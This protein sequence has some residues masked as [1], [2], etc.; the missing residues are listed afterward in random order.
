[1]CTN[2]G[3]CGRQKTKK[4][5]RTMKSRVFACITVMTLFVALAMPARLAGQV[6][7]T[8]TAHRIPMW[9]SNTTLGDS[10]I[11]QTGVGSVGT[12]LQVT[13]GAGLTGRFGHNGWPGGSINLTGGHGGGAGTSVSGGSG[14]SVQITGGTGGSGTTCC[15]QNGNGNGGSITLQPGA[16]GTFVLTHGRSGNV[17]LVPTRAASSASGQRTRRPRWTLQLV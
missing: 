15:A 12:S 4:A 14:G 6:G 3:A 11:F 13:G 17:I 1:M 8:G 10:I 9:T 16:G 2:R 7:G 5:R